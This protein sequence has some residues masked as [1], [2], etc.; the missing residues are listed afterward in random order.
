[1]SNHRKPTIKND[2][3]NKGKAVGQKNPFTPNQAELIRTIL[4]S[5]HQAFTEEA[6]QH[7]ANGKASKSQAVSRKALGALRDLAMFNTG[8]DTM[9]RA[10]DLLKLRVIDVADHNGD[11][12]E[13]FSIRQKKTKNTQVV[14]L[15]HNSRDALKSWI[16]SSNKTS[17]DFLFTS[18]GNRNNGGPLS[19]NQYANLV[20]KWAS[21]AR[22]DPKRHSTHSM[23]RSKSAAV[24][25]A[26]HNLRACQHLLGHK[27]IAS[28]ASYLAVD[29]R[30]A[31]DLA[32]KI[33]V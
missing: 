20:K 31:L 30:E 29:Q 21:H 5:D 10:S 32:K 11:T 18:V 14:A 8:V 12:I 6:A 22:L 25:Q 28:T 1:M 2:P 33:K 4:K 15:S 17:E 7:A 19:R 24:Y 23:R 13:E 27:S 3:W 16:S 26:T 9:L